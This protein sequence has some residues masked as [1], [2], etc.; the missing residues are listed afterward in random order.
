[1]DDFTWEN[2]VV[3]AGAHVAEDASEPTLQRRFVNRPQIHDEYD[4]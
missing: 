3:V 2:L 4:P 1:M